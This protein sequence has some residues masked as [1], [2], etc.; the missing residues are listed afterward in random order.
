M[1]GSSGRRGCSISILRRST[2]ELVDA[3]VATGVPY[4][5]LSL[6]HVSRPPGR[7]DAAVG[8][9][10]RASSSASNAIRA[11]APDAATFRSSFILGYPGE[12]E[13]RPRPLLAFL[14]EAQLDWAGFFTFSARGRHLR[15]RAGRPG[16]SADWP[17]S[18]CAS[19]PSSRTPSPPSRR[20][21]LVGA[22]RRV[23][24]DGPGMGSDRARGARDRRRRAP[25]ARARRGPP[26][27]RADHRC[28]GPRPVGR[29]HRGGP[30]DRRGAPLVA[31][32][33]V[34]GWWYPQRESRRPRAP[35]RLRVRFGPSRPRHPSQRHHRGPAGGAPV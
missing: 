6:Q 31:P 26:V 24:V 13:E 20:T 35:G 29:A 34:R 5:D 28:G 23:L 30:V 17:W 3:I 33:A 14:E 15:R 32:D 4:F 21:A 8:R 18:A 27:R 16:T 22:V 10:R 11:A 1:S 2:D 12:T 7:A 9:R 25:A 19:A